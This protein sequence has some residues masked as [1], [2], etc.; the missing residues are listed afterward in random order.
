MQD[1]TASRECPNLTPP[2]HRRLRLAISGAQRRLSSVGGGWASWLHAR[3]VVTK[4]RLAR[5]LIAAASVSILYYA[6]WWLE[7]GHVYNL[8]LLA[9]LLFAI[10]YH[11]SQVLMAWLIYLRI[12][13]P[14]ECAAPH[15]L[16]VDVFIPVYDEP[17]DLVGACLRAAV[18][19]RY[20][21]HTYLLDDRPSLARRVLA[22]TLGVVYLT[23]PDNRDA[24]AG[25][26]NHALALTNS[27]FVV[28]FDVD[29]IPVSGFLDRVLGHFADPR[30]SFVQ[31]LV[32]HSNQAE[33]FVARAAA[34]QAYDV[35]SP[36]SMGMHGWGAATVWGAHWLPLMLMVILVRKMMLAMWERDQQAVHSGIAGVGLAFG[37]WPVHVRTLLCALLRVR[38]PHIAT[39][40]RAAGGNYLPLVIPQLVAIALLLAGMVY[41]LSAGVDLSAAVVLFFAALNIVLHAPVL[42]AVW[43]GRVLARQSAIAS[44]HA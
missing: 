22:D 23:R 40:K 6:S 44:G 4:R 33:S 16:S 10:V 2:V 36:T 1:H 39:P 32:A 30:V 25:N 20:P 17:D 31:A 21:H 42:Y 8:F 34:D 13:M 19:M 26:V 12:D 28:V 3:S 41:R 38:V 27:E 14:A 43:E 29:H 15:G 9:A 18:N 37:V 24:K 5:A 7:N 11:G 35:F